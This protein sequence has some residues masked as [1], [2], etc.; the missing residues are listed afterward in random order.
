M[1]DSLTAS[2]TYVQ[3]ILDA[4]KRAI[5]GKD[6]YDDEYYALF[7]STIQP[8][9]EKRLTDAIVDT[10]SII[11]AAWI[12]AGKPAVPLAVQRSPRT[13]KKGL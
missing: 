3:A 8:I 6:V 2:F 4:D 11:T 9:L 1:F 7:F 13:V 12:E 5:A 10:A